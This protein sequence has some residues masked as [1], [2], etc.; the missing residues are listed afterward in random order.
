MYVLLTLRVLAWIKVY[1]ALKIGPKIIPLQ[2]LPNTGVRIPHNF[3]TKRFTRSKNM[4]LLLM[5][6]LYNINILYY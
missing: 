4:S 2:C 3:P 6:D 1:N 5:A